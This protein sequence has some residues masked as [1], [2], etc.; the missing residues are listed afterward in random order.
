MHSS[1]RR[2]GYHRRYK[3][4]RFYQNGYCKF[5]DLCHFKHLRKKSS[6][7]KH[8]R[9]RRKPISFKTPSAPYWQILKSLPCQHVN[10]YDNSMVSNIVQLNEHE[11]ILCSHIE[12]CSYPMLLY[13]Y[14]ITFNQ[15]TKVCNYTQESNILP[16][17]CINDFR[18]CSS[19][20]LYHNGDVS[21]YDLQS[22]NTTHKELR[23]PKK[24]WRV[25]TIF[26]HNEYHLIGHAYG[27]NRRT[28]YIYDHQQN[29]WIK[30]F[31]LFG[32]TMD[33]KWCNC[34]QIFFIKT[35]FVLLYIC[36]N[37]VWN[38]AIKC[39]TWRKVMTLPTTISSCSK[40]MTNDENYMILLGS[41]DDRPVLN[42]NKEIQR[43]YV[44][45]IERMRCYKSNIL[46]PVKGGFEPIVM[47]GAVAGIPIIRAF[48]WIHG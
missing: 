13:K 8:T 25:A 35:K 19:L 4:C 41:S 45:N 24:C 42:V 43:I 20:H 29:D 33:S 48:L 39:R 9:T 44:L 6:K 21:V 46:C 34:G 22:T 18:S 47:N 32:D 36:N 5:G 1:N 26:A 14:H 17:L 10:R 31:A 11:F 2:H 37:Q 3:I 30:I 28:H 23:P 12:P 27:T 40:A 15:W 7:N 16:K 38:Y